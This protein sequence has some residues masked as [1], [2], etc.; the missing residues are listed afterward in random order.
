MACP[1]L[2][3]EQSGCWVRDKRL[4]SCWTHNAKHD[5]QLKMISSTKSRPPSELHHSAPEQRKLL[6]PQL[7]QKVTTPDKPP[8]CREQHREFPV[9]LSDLIQRVSWSFV[10]PLTQQQEVADSSSDGQKGVTS[11]NEQHQEGEGKW[12]EHPDGQCM[13]LHVMDGDEGLVVL[14]HKPLCE[15]QP[16]AQAQGQTRFHRG[17]HSSQ[18]ARLHAAAAQSLVDDALNIL[19]VKLLSY[20]GNDPTSPEAMRRRTQT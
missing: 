12:V 16:D 2:S 10:Q 6:A 9:L 3:V 14:P 11:R 8:T 1:P 5:E 7:L 15:L 20:S 17:G 4:A 19:A 13:C 18:L